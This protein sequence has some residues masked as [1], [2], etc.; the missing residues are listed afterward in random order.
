MV[1]KSKGQT[2]GEKH[3]AREKS[4]V[5]RCEGWP[6]F[7]QPSFEA[8]HPL[9]R[10][11]PL[12]QPT[13]P[14]QRI[15][16]EPVSAEVGAPTGSR[17]ERACWAVAARRWLEQPRGPAALHVPSFDPRIQ[18]SGNSERGCEGTAGGPP[19][20]QVMAGTCRKLRRFCWS[21][22]QSEGV[23]S[24]GRRESGSNGHCDWCMAEWTAG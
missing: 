20:V 24:G 22:V 5:K 17:L 4:Q 6:A 7:E 16:W 1:R 14:D 2:R 13:I 21:A 10:P 18:H 8:A 9:E 15:M 3:N 11:D 12:G 19:A 23:A